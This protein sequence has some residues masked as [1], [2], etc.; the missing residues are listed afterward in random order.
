MPCVEEKL[1][2]VA[3]L[4]QK[5]SRRPSPQ[6]NTLQSMMTPR[7]M[8]DPDLYLNKISVQ[9]PNVEAF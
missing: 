3:M 1:D 6:Y 9:S 7:C 8:I 2:T 5:I 4:V